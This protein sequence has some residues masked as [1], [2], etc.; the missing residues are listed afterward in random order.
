MIILSV[1]KYKRM[2]CPDHIHHAVE[3][4]VVNLSASAGCSI[5]RYQRR[6]KTLPDLA[7]MFENAANSMRFAHENPGYDPIGLSWAPEVERAMVEYFKAIHPDY[8]KNLINTLE[9][10]K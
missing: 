6:P 5:C 9:K 10:L 7:R 2:I 4:R 1:P 8:R 3:G